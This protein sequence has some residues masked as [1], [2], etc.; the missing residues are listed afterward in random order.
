[1]NSEKT[2]KHKKITK[3][4]FVWQ[5]YSDGLLSLELDI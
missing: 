2:K 1:M 5:Y 3:Y 4:W